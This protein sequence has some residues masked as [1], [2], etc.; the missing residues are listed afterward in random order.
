MS[1]FMDRLQALPHRAGSH[2]AYHFD[3]GGVR[4]GSDTPNVEV[5]Y[6]R[7]TYPLDQLTHLVLDVIVSRVE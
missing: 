3:N 6:L 7:V 5:S 2:A 4:L 1:N